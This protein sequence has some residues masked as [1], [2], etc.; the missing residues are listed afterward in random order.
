MSKTL[1]SDLCA[2]SGCNENR[3]YYCDQHR[4]NGMRGY[5]GKIVYL[6]ESEGQ[7]I[8]KKVSGG[9]PIFICL[10]AIKTS[11]GLKPGPYTELVFQNINNTKTRKDS[12]GTGSS[13]DPSLKMRLTKLQHDALDEISLRKNCTKGTLII[14]FIRKFFR[15]F[16]DIE[17]DGRKKYVLTRQDSEHI[18]H[19]KSKTYQS[20][21]VNVPPDL[22]A[23]IISFC[24]RKVSRHVS[25][26]EF[27]SIV[28][29][30]GITEELNNIP[31]FLKVTTNQW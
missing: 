16:D 7:M 22:N 17:E 5:M 30:L 31:M 3:S 4:I 8:M 27:G 19:L 6:E 9:R 13:K 2:V 23:K 28:I 1:F 10:D 14:Q 18:R 29:S 21:S 26:N 25:R 12:S 11:D 24:R 20:M 15:G